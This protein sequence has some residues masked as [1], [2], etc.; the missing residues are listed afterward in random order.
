MS[1]GFLISHSKRSSGGGADLSVILPSR[2]G[3]LF[4]PFFIGKYFLL[5]E[6]LRTLAVLNNQQVEIM[7]KVKKIEQ[8]T[9]EHFAPDGTSLG[10]LTDLENMDLRLQIANE[11]AEGYYI[12]FKDK[13]INI[14]KDGEMDA[15]PVGMYDQMMKPMANLFQLRRKR[16]KGKR[17]VNIEKI[18]KKSEDLEREFFKHLDDQK[19]EWKQPGVNLFFVDIFCSETTLENIKS[20][21]PEME[22]MI[23]PE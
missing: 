21:F 7:I 19:I 11:E 18:M 2:D 22:I 10:F 17:K 4:C 23:K 6:F 13:K 3:I 16:N 8:P 12:V 5:S 9:A 15:W 20:I 1:Y 14:D